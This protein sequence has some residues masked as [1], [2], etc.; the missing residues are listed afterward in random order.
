LR[1]GKF[2]GRYDTTKEVTREFIKD[3]Q[4]YTITDDTALD[5]VPI[6][7]FDV[8]ATEEHASIHSRV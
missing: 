6:F 8:V 4:V 7:E 3:G 2:N 1:G 5:G